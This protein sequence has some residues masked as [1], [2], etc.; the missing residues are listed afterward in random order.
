MFKTL[1]SNAGVVGSIPRQGTKIQHATRCNQEFFKKKRKTR[2]W[3]PGAEA[4]ASRELVFHRDRAVVLQDE[5][6]ERQM[7]VRFAEQSECT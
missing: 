5:K 6:R 3:V 1:P 4:G 7:V 2:W